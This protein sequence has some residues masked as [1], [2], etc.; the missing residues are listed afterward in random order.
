M[1]K[2]I[3]LQSFW[4]AA[5]ILGAGNGNAFF[6]LAL[7]VSALNYVVFKPNQPF[8]AYGLFVIGFSLYGFAQDGLLAL[9]GAVAYPEGDVPLWLN[10]LYIV[11]ICYYGDILNRLAKMRT[12]LLALLGGVGGVFSFYAGANLAGLEVLSNWYYAGVFVSWA[13][14]FPVSMR[15]YYGGAGCREES[16]LD[17]LKDASVYFSFDQSGYERHAKNFTD[18]LEFKPSGQALVTGGTSGIGLAAASALAE[19]GVKTFIA[20]RSKAKGEEASG[21]NPNL[22]FMEI[23]LADWEA[24]LAA[25][26][27]LPA[28]DYLVLN[29]GGMPDSCLE[30]R[31]GVES[32][33]ASQLCG[34]YFLLKRLLA[35]GKLKEGARIVWMS[36]GGMYLKSLDMDS[37]FK[38]GSDYDKVAVYANVKRA[39]VTLLEKFQQEFSRQ[40]I[41]GMHPGWVDTPGIQSAI[42]GFAKRL[43]HRL[44]SAEAGADT[45]LWLLSETTA[46]KVGEFFFDRKQAKKH[47]LWFTKNSD[48]LADELY[49]KMNRYYAE[50]NL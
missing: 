40:N 38:C 41:Y 10:S 47:F 42:P 20:G 35:L 30:N 2:V 33:A 25:C 16:V 44:R 43:Q 5:V 24:S 12:L 48:R 27:E 34:H 29:A 23:D 36:S 18:A 32:Q 13:M 14:F 39:Q 46:P 9:S 49:E 7:V 3:L 4:Y 21:L 31:H 1:F 22:V 17:K 11:F 28:M 6:L 8:F 19:K 26:K 15:M 50:I 45:A 37:L